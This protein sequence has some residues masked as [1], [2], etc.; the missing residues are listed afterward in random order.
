MPCAIIGPSRALVPLIPALTPLPVVHPAI[1]ALRDLLR[2]RFAA[3]AEMVWPVAPIAVHAVK[4]HIQ[5]VQH[6]IRRWLAVQYARDH[7]PT[8]GGPLV[9]AQARYGTP[10]KIQLLS[11]VIQRADTLEAVKTHLFTMDDFPHGLREAQRFVEH[12]CFVWGVR[13]CHT[14]AAVLPVRWDAHGQLQVFR[15]CAEHTP[16]FPADALFDRAH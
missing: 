3:P 5:R 13:L 11:L 1:T 12:L 8:I 16:R 15:L 9:A 7:A 2:L 14:H 6:D 10:G 4:P